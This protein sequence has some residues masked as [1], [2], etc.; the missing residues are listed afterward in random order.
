GE[1]DPG[2]VDSG[3]DPEVL[4]GEDPAPVPKAVPL[5]NLTDGHA[6]A[7]RDAP[8][9]I[10]PA[11]PMAPP[12]RCRRPTRRRLR[13]QVHPRPDRRTLPDPEPPALYP[14]VR[15]SELGDGRTVP[16]RDVAERF[17]APDRVLARREAP[18]LGH[19]L[20]VARKAL[21]PPNGKP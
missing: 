4:P 9:G 6:V 13:R 5:L 2:A 7:P 10:A 20:E 14:A 12:L 17:A 21:A 11:D 1:G 3:P 8:E 16:P 19:M 18:L 15:G